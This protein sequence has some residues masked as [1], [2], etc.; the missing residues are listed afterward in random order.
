MP[1]QNAI[2]KLT[3]AKTLMAQIR[4]ELRN[5]ADDVERNASNIGED[6]CARALREIAD[7]YQYAINQVGR[8]V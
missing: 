3:Y 2:N 4:N 1:D 6:R 8:V 5:I 7:D